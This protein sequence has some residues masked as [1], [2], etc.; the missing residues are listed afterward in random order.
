MRSQILV[1]PRVSKCKLRCY[2]DKWDD[3][4]SARTNRFLKTAEELNPHSVDA[5]KKKVIC[6]SVLAEGVS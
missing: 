1:I 6:S 2:C 3:I 5:V 4:N